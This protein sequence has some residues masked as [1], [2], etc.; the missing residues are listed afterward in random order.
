[1]AFFP[2]VSLGSL[3]CDPL[4]ETF[5]SVGVARGPKGLRS[6]DLSYMTRRYELKV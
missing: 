2:P 1:M 6:K 5:E 3:P 4:R